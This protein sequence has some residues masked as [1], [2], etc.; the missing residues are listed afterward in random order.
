MTRWPCPRSHST[1][2]SIPFQFYKPLPPPKEKAST[3]TPPCFPSARTEHAV[4]KDD[5]AGFFQAVVSLV[6]ESFDALQ[7][8]LGCS[9]VSG[10]LFQESAAF[11]R[12]PVVQSGLDFIP[13][14]HPDQVARIKALRRLGI[15]RRIRRVRPA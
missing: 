9:A 4:E 3:V 2:D 6:D 14:T 8:P 5:A 10:H 12:L 11:E 15:Q 1:E 13:G 7:N